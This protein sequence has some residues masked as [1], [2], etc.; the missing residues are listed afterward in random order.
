MDEKFKNFGVIVSSMRNR[1]ISLIDGNKF[2]NV[3]MLVSIVKALYFSSRD[4]TTVFFCIRNI[5]P[6]FIPGEWQQE[7]REYED[8]EISG[9]S[10][11]VH[12][13]GKHEVTIRISC[14]GHL[15]V[16]NVWEDQACS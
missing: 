15:I 6:Q 2:K 5:I 8:S 12:V 14:D 1:I 13:M 11:C 10:L 4:T 7:I 3:S 9:S 16:L